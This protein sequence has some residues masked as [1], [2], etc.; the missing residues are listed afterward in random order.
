[1]SQHTICPDCGKT[2]HLSCWPFCPHEMVRNR[3]AEIA[4]KDSTIV[5]KKRDGSY[6]Y[7]MDNRKST[8]PGCERIVL[9]S[10]RKIEQ[11]E[12]MANVRSEVAHF[13]SGTGRGHDDNF[14]GERYN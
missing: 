14:R 10:L 8:P 12:R 1:M 2:V 11:H 13:D 5:F 4:E 3:D 9:N 7:P 6:S